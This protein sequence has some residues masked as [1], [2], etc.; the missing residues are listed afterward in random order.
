MSDIFEMI[1]AE[2][3]K[4]RGMDSEA[5]EKYSAEMEDHDPIWDDIYDIAYTI[6]TQDLECINWEISNT[7]I[8]ASYELLNDD[9]LNYIDF[10]RLPNGFDNLFLEAA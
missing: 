3:E 7:P 10:L 2:I 5:F 1:H 8:H 9:I 4:V 6:S